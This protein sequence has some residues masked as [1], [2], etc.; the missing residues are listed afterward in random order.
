MTARIDVVK[1]EKLKSMELSSK[2][3]CFSFFFFSIIHIDDHADKSIGEGIHPISAIKNVRPT[4]DSR[5]G[6]T[7]SSDGLTVI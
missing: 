6:D 4:E 2:E 5:V 1:Y 7:K 3:N